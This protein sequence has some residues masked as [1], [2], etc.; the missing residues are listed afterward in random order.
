MRPFT[1]RELLG[2]GLIFLIVFLVTFQGLVV[3]K[4]RARDAQR[5]ADLG[6]IS[7]ALYTFYEEFGFFPP[8]EV[9]KIKACKGV[10]YEEVLTE[11]KAKKD[12]DRELFFTGL[13]PCYWGADPLRDITSSD[14]APYLA[15]IPVDPKGGEGYTYLY[16]S[17]TYRF[18]LYTFLEGETEEDGYDSR[19]VSRDLSCGRAIC[20]FGKSYGQTPLDV[21]IEDYEQKLLD[22]SRGGKP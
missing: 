14:R 11:L 22:E 3:A 2:V 7:D 18:Q 15:T 1:K 10:A 6:A 4:R 17:N 16:I 20:S 8:A 19:I 12:F 9:G 13:R 21:S 5:K